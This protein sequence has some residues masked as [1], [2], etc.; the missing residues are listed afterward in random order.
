MYRIPY[1]TI[2]V[3]ENFNINAADYGIENGGVVI[4]NPNAPVGICEP[5]SKIEEVVVRNPSSVVIVDEA[6]IDFGGESALPL[7]NKYENLLVVQTFSKS[8][9]MAG[10]RIGYAIGCKKIIKY[11]LDAKFSFNSYTMNMPALTLGAAAVK[12]KEYFEECREKVIATRER[13]KPLLKEL[14]FTFGDSK[15]NFIFAKHKEKHG[16]EIFDYLRQNGIVVR[17]FDQPRISEYLRI[18]IGTDEEMD[19]LISVLK[20]FVVS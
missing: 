15:T 17:R 5:V 8:R 4:A 14:G 13:V 6:Y 11:L 7:I 20:E 18:S 3:D 16:K 9:S 12:D 1:K 10:M 2:P 19:R